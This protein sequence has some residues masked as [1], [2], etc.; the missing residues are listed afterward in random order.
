MDTNELIEKIK[1]FIPD[2]WNKMII[3]WWK[4]LVWKKKELKN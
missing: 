4:R 1:N 2:N 3:C